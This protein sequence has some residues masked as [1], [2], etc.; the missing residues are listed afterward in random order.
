MPRY[1]ITARG[2]LLS[3]AGLAPTGAVVE[4]T[5]AAAAS[6]P[7]GTV[8]QLP[9]A[10]PSLAPAVVAPPVVPTIEAPKTGRKGSKP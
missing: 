2:G 9:D 7:L 8:E 3:R 10:P 1:T 4:M 5:A 6:L